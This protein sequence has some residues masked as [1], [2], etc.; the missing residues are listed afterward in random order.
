MASP[1]SSAKNIQII[2]QEVFNRHRNRSEP[3]RRLANLISLKTIHR[4]LS[5]L[6]DRDEVAIAEL[7]K[8]LA[9]LEKPKK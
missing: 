2:V 5:E 6:K 3:E 4:N 1:Q 8:H 7:E 9:K